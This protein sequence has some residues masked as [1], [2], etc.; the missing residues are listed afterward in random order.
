MIMIQISIFPK[1]KL[2]TYLNKLFLPSR[3][4]LSFKPYGFSAQW[5]IK[6]KILTPKKDNI[7]NRSIV[8]ER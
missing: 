6:K 4:L 1:T 3:Q 5:L 8:V 2:K 7:Q